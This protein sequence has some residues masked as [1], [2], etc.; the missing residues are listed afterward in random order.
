MNGATVVKGT[1]GDFRSLS[2]IEVRKV[3]NPFNYNTLPR[4]NESICFHF[5]NSGSTY[6]ERIQYLNFTGEPIRI[7]QRD[8]T[9][10]TLFPEPHYSSYSPRQ[11]LY[12]RK[13]PTPNRNVE[14]AYALRQT[15]ALDADSEEAQVLRS[16]I[17]EYVSKN[18]NG[19]ALI[20]NQDASIE[21]FIPNS[22]LF[23]ECGTPLYIHETDVVVC[24]AGVRSNS[25][26]PHF[27][28]TS[29]VDRVNNISKENESKHAG[30]RM[31]INDIKMG[32]SPRYLSVGGIIIKIEVICDEDLEEGFYVKSFN[33]FIQG[34]GDIPAQMKRYS[35]EEADKQFL[36]GGT[37]EEAKMRGHHE[38]ISL[39]QRELEIKHEEMELN[40]DIGK[41]KLE[42]E[43]KK[44]SLA[45][46]QHGFSERRQAH[47]AQ[48]YSYTKRRDFRSEVLD[49][50]KFIFSAIGTLF[51]IKGALS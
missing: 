48:Q 15:S 13:Q 40:R 41:A 39:K 25:Q 5:N 47:D 50:L 18:H 24:H 35:M 46:M 32:Y 33:E 42:T 43:A 17:S 27:R 12:I 44:V 14:I 51:M 29:D 11:G 22:K 36:L 20:K 30:F 21:Y 7:L 3:V 31:F 26:H 37:P 49:W 23:P 45:E 19:H 9:E 1:Y 16:V 4:Y 6:L 28:S 10:V 38:Q 2:N 34:N 8:H